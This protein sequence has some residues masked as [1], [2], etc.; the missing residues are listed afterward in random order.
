[1]TECLDRYSDMLEEKDI[2]RLTQY[3][4]SVFGTD[5]KFHSPDGDSVSS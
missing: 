2:K 3:N 1:M 5:E 4:G